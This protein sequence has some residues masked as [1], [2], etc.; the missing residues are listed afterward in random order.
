[1]ADDK[2]LA[3]GAERQADPAKEASLCAGKLEEP[4]RGMRMAA[5]TTG[6]YETEHGKF[7]KIQIL[8]IDE[9]FE[10]KRPHM[11]WVDPSVFRKR[12]HRS[13]HRLWRGRLGASRRRIA[14]CLTS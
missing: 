2:R 7:E 14:P 10:G 5:S 11:S 6:F 4:T 9:L 1:M 12:P 8:T 3:T 13:R